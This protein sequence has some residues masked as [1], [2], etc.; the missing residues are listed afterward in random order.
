MVLC[1]LAGN[2]ISARVASP[3]GEDGGDRA[4]VGNTVLPGYG[5]KKGEDLAEL[6][7]WSLLEEM[8]FKNHLVFR[9]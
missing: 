9:G 1:G 3:Q 7:R 8:H 4:T 6:G 5:S 2:F